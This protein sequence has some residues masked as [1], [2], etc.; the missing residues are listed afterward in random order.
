M[1]QISSFYYL[2]YQTM[3]H[4]AETLS[5]TSSFEELLRI[6]C[7]AFE[8]AEQPVRHNEDKYNE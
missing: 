2:S 8:F 1:G 5:P 3:K 6:L 7:D 4:F